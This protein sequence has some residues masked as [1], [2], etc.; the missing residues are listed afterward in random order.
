MHI[1]TILEYEGQKFPLEYNDI[2]DFSSLP[3][4]LCTQIYG[5]CFVGDEI[6][7]AKNG[8]KNTWGLPGGTIEK[9]ETIEQTF[10]REIA[11]EI[12]AEIL[13][14]RSVG[15]QKVGRL[16]GTFGYQ[17]RACALVRKMGKFVSDPAGS[18]TE[19]ATISP[20]D[21]KKYFDWGAVG[22]RTIQRAIEIKK[23]L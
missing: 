10:R 13:K 5:V 19:N 14:W 4:E 12:N 8:R 11:E 9:G 1:D 20:A 6:I 2:D 7:I 23:S 18:I 3:R 21:C 17:L 16:D 15:Y 22:E